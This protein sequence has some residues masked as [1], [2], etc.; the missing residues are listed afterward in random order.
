[1]KPVGFEDLTDVF[2]L[3]LT[4]FFP[5]LLSGSRREKVLRLIGDISCTFSMG[6]RR[7]IENRLRLVLGSERASDQRNRL[8]REVF[9]HRW[10]NREIMLLKKVSL[11]RVD[12]RLICQGVRVEGL[13]YL[14]EALSR[15]KGAILWESSFGKRLLGKV[16]LME[17][18]FSICQIHGPEHGGSPTWFGQSVIRKI[19]R[20]TEAKLFAEVI[21]IQY[22]SLAYL[23]LLVNRLKQNAVVCI[24]GLGEAGHKFLPVEFL[25]GEQHFATG[26]V[27]LA[28]KTGASLIPI[29]CFREDDGTNHL[30]LE[31]PLALNHGAEYLRQGVL[32]YATLLQS[33]IRAHPEQWPR[34]HKLPWTK[35]SAEHTPNPERAVIP[36]QAGRLEN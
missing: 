30:V 12:R 5:W 10:I 28:R 27:N 4:K 2:L 14:S 21:D 9:R 8:T 29:F 3:L 33:Y 23:R 22:D 31:E 15:G 25:G 18:G 17:N 19:H 16:V 20:K 35:K 1:M 36:R 32:R 24:P 34:W 7:V 26:L 11:S 13:K 6:Q